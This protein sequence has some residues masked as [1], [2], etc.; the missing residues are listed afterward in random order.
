LFSACWR[1]AVLAWLGRTATA[2]TSMLVRRLSSGS[3]RIASLACL[4]T[5]SFAAA[6]ASS[7]TPAKAVLLSTAR[8]AGQQ[9]MLMLMMMLA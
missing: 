4:T 6:S 1:K 9:L 8:R 5:S 3:T 7:S 2:G